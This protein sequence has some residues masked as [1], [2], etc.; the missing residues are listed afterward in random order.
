MDWRRHL[1]KNCK[2]WIFARSV[3]TGNRVWGPRGVSSLP[4]YRR[5]ALLSLLMARYCFLGRAERHLTVYPPIPS[6]RISNSVA[7]VGS[8]VATWLNEIRGCSRVVF[9]FPG[10]CMWLMFRCESSSNP[11]VNLSEVRRRVVLKEV[12]LFHSVRRNTRI[13]LNQI[14]DSNLILICIFFLLFM[15]FKMIDLWF[16]IYSMGYILN[17]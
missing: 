10:K 7:M 3:M 15:A 11:Y 5:L 2:Q 4:A 17:R 8:A 6:Y 16:D 9:R 1:V 13:N 12:A 14:F